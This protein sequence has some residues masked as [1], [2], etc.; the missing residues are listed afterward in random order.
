MQQRLQNAYKA[1]SYTHLDVYKRQVLALMNTPED[2]FADAYSYISV[3]CMGIVASVAY[4]YFA[5]CL[6]AIGNSKVPLVTLVFSACLNVVL[7]P[8]SYTHLRQLSES[9]GEIS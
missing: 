7:D 8:G 5:A 1:V 3:I 9:T 4:N 6:R 2:I